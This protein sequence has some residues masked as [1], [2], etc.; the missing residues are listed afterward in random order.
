MHKVSIEYMIKAVKLMERGHCFD[1]RW[2]LVLHVSSSPY[3]YCALQLLSLSIILLASSPASPIFF[4]AREKNIGE[5]GD[6]AI[7]L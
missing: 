7:I 4:N 5:A 3:I 6:E 2:R 1:G